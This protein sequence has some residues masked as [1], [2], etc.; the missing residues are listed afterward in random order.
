MNPVREKLKSVL[1]YGVLKEL[2]ADLYTFDYLNFA[3]YHDKLESARLKSGE[4]DAVIAGIGSIASCK[5]V[6]AAFEPLFMMGSMGLVAG[7]KIIRSFRLV[8]SRYHVFRFRRSQN[9]GR[10][11]IT[12]TNGQNVVVCL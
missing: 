6:I 4:R 7:E 1:D 10:C 8:A 11:G 2:W 3:N 12:D 9:A 5:C